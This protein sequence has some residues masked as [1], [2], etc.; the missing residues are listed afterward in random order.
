MI[1]FGQ[2]VLKN[3]EIASRKEFLLTNSLGCYSS[4]SIIGLN[5]RKYHG[6]LVSGN[7]FLAKLE[8]EVKG[9]K[10]SVNRFSN[11]IHP[12]GYKYL[13]SF[14]LYPPTF[15]YHTEE[16]VVIKTLHLSNTSRTL[17]VFYDI[18]PKERV[19]FKIT[20]LVTERGTNELRKDFDFKQKKIDK[21]IE[22]GKL[23]ITANIEFYEN[24]DI[25]WNFFYERD[26]ER[27]YECEENLYCPGNF[28]CETD[29]KMRIEVIATIDNVSKYSIEELKKP[30]NVIEC[31]DITANTFLVNE[32]LLAGYH[33]FTESWGRDTFISLPGLLLVRRKFEEAK[34]IMKLYAKHMK[35]GV[36][37]NILPGRY[38][39]ADA[40]LWFIYS[41][42]KYYEYTEDDEFLKEMKPYIKEFLEKYSKNRAIRED[43]DGLIEVDACM[44]WMD[45]KYTPRSG[46]PVEINALW[47]NALSAIEELYGF[48]CESSRVKKNFKKFWNNGK[49][50]DVIDPNDES[51]RP[52]QLF[53]VALPHR[54][55]SNSK[56]IKILK[57]LEGLV[58][59]YG[60]RT[61]S[62]EDRRYKGRFSGDESYHNGCVWAWLM[63]FYITSYMKVFGDEDYCKILVQPLLE[64]VKDAGL[65]SI[66]EIFDGD[67]PHNPNGCISQAWSV[68]EILRC[69]HEDLDV[70]LF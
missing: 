62:K 26:Y 9:R 42:Q 13:E 64:H 28:Y 58:T 31:L 19:S 57:A 40:T 69:V 3:Y 50:F 67:R 4:S 1:H 46:K 24:P 15:H 56:E 70:S 51:L 25:Y 21:G 68:A 36:I 34:K 32:Q 52:N 54:I 17:A 60:L 65:G 63:G 7:V 29:K 23:S 16:A 49:L 37:P 66:S 53:A 61:L 11:S 48:E 2:E 30:E 55:F 33:W 44:T 22:V 39:S 5:T 35:N 43:K 45:T 20:P 27:G 59:P 14:E 41:I 10:L 47:F 38:N 12:E 8:E 6:L 18:F